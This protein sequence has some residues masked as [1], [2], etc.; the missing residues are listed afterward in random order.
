MKQVI[1]SSLLVVGAF[2]GTDSPASPGSARARPTGLAIGPDG[3]VYISDSVTGRILK[4]A[5]TGS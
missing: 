4:I 5:L 1:I 3:S 2:T